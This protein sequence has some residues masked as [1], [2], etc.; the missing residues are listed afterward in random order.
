MNLL[1]PFL[2]RGCRYL[3]GGRQHPLMCIFGRFHVI[4]CLLDA[5]VR[6]SHVKRPF[7]YVASLFKSRN[8][9]E[10]R[11]AMD[12][13]SYVDPHYL[14]SLKT[15]SVEYPSCCRWPLKEEGVR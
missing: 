14:G 3:E 7:Q 15:Y 11:E 1:Q 4:R 10:M 13:I 5:Q 12:P 8:H 6:G 2:G 9:A